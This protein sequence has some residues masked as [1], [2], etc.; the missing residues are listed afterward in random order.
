MLE[1]AGATLATDH[2]EFRK[3]NASKLRDAAERLAKEI[4]VRKRT[5]AGEAASI[6]DYE[7]KTL[8]PLIA[9]LEP[10]FQDPSHKGKWKN[11]NELLSPGPHDAEVPTVN[12]LRVAFGD[13]KRFRRDYL[14]AGDGA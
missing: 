3:S 14:G 12:D 5:E 9:D 4:V 11:A 13:L 2:P 6:A 7:G 1:R 10:Y 8:G